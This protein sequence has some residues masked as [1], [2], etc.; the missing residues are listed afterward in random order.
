MKYI[1]RLTTAIQLPDLNVT[2]NRWKGSFSIKTHTK[3]C[4]L[5][6]Q[7]PSLAFT[8]QYC[9]HEIRN[10][11]G[12]PIL[13]R[14]LDGAEDFLCYRVNISIYNRSNLRCYGDAAI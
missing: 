1:P 11:A 6:V 10:I 9:A 4:L 2:I 7:C 3:T 14:T 5:G 8:T 13:V 12:E